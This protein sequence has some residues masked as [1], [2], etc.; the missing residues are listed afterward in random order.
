LDVIS[1]G[2]Y[3]YAGKGDDFSPFVKAAA[4]LQTG[5]IRIWPGCDWKGSRE[6]DAGMRRK[7]VDDIREAAVKAA[8]GGMKIALE[9]HANTLTDTLSS[10]LQLLEEVNRDNLF[11][12]WQPPKGL[13]ADENASALR[14]LVTAGKLIN[15]HTHYW[16]DDVQLPLAEGAEEWKR[17]IAAAAPANP[18]FLIEFVKENDP[19]YF[20]KDVK[21]LKGWVNDGI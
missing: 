2:S 16:R 10:T 20:K 13:T 7:V 4:A 11:T 12:Y 21:T 14:Q 1:Y 19:E 3:Y 18:A 5:T 15:L 8:D 9:Y 17:Y 6:T